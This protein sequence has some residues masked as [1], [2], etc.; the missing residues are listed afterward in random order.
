MKQNSRHYIR[1]PTLIANIPVK[2]PITTTN[3]AISWFH[4]DLESIVAETYL[5]QT[6]KHHLQPASTTGIPPPMDFKTA[7]KANA[8]VPKP[9]FV[10]SATLAGFTQRRG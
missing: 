4:S 3:Q 9:R 5:M 10:L 1:S 2:N 6:T 8:S 7:P